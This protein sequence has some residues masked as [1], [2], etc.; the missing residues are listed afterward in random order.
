M[1]LPQQPPDARQIFENHDVVRKAFANSE[2]QAFV[3]HCETHY[4]HWDQIRFRT[5]P[6]IDPEVVWAFVKFGRLSNYRT[7][8]L[9]GDGESVLR[10]NIPDP[11]QREI[12][13]IDQQFAGRLLSDDESPFT[14]SHRERFIVSALREEAIAS[15]MLEG[16]ATTRREAKQ[17]LKSGRKPRSRGEQMVLNNYR[18]IM[19]IREHRKVDLTPEFLIE[20]QTILTEGT[21]E[22]SDEVGRFRSDNDNVTVVDRRDDQIIHLPPPASELEARIAQLCSFANHSRGEDFIH[23]V[24]KAC[25]L[26]FQLGFDHPFCDGNGRTAR[27]LFYW[28]MLRSGYWL[29]EYLPISRLIYRAPARYVRS[30]L[31][32]ETDEFDITYF[33]VY[34]AR[35]IATARQELERYLEEKQTQF[36]QARRIFSSDRRLNHRQREILLS[37]VRNQD[38]V[39]TIANHQRR[40][41]IAYGTARSDLMDLA[42]WEYLRI[43][44]V[45]KRYEF[46][47]GPRIDGLE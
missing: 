4:Y 42:D 39:F 9:R 36:T 21:Q 20:L 1:R 8:P 12:M 43:I 46:F 37:A 3:R 30:F 6:T 14:Q 44:Q 10:Y 2:L 27:A 11:V 26:H 25:I 5:P 35:I 33:L 32:C 47:A 28:S 40:H 24:V 23:P 45:G 17:M 13:L 18:A 41:G 19:F 34:H 16:A 38:R 7:V 22:Q 29:F 31:Y 15:S